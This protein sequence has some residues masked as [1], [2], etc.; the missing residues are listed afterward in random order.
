MRVVTTIKALRRLLNTARSKG[1]T[2][3]FVP[4][5]G[6]FHEGHASLMRHSKKENDLTVVSIFVNPKQFGPREDFSKYPRDMKKD[7]KLAKKE[8]VDII[9]YPSVD[10]IYP[11]GYLTYVETGGLSD[12][13]CGQSRPGHFKG[14]TTVVAK[15]INIVQPDVMYLGQKDAQQALIIRKMAQDLNFPVSIK[16]MPTVR[17]KDGLAM[18]SRNVYLTPQERSEAPQLYRSLKEAKKNILAGEHSTPKII[19]MV[20]AMI[21]GSTTGKID[22]IECVDVKN[23]NKVKKISGTVLI[24]L[25]VY[26]GKTRLIDN[27]IVGKS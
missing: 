5:M 7:E 14:V 19:R 11:T 17:E 6:Y 10:E 23:L 12:A 1:K 8:N 9:F 13:L 26:F 21:K 3:G 24:A 27:V 4:T 25:A 15:L 22:Y 16:V 20:I 2:I 18:S